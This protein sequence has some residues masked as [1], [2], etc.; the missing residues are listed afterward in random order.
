MDT[1]MDWE[2]LQAEAEAEARA[3]ATLEALEQAR[4][5]WLGR[6]GKLTAVLRQVGSL[7]KD[8]RKA[9]GE[10]SNRVKAAVEALFAEREARLEAEALERELAAGAGFDPTLPGTVE[11]AGS[12][13]PVTLVQY[14]IEDI[15][16]GLGF[17]VLDGP[18]CESDY[19][20]FEALNIPAYH[21]ARDAQDTFYCDNGRVLRTHTSACQGRALE[22]YPPPLRAIFPG[23]CFRAE[24]VDASHDM[25]FYQLE[26]LMI[27]RDIS[28]ANLI[29]VMKF[30]LS[31]VFQREVEVR[32]RPGYFPFVE[33]GFEL[34]LKCLLCGGAGCKT[35]K[36]SGWV[37][38]LPCGLVH[39]NVLALSGVDPNEWSGF[40]FGLGLTRLAMMKY[41]IND[42]R[43]LTGGDVRFLSQFP[44]G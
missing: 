37:E 18:E 35:C 9:F 14:E 10:A 39:P 1:A 26:G 6:H 8:R 24:S 40:A 2:A 15:F 5:A 42:I 44:A 28:V 30:L 17:M 33:P 4:T 41:G 36:Q 7:P 27:D 20:N 13:H 23:R 21:P 11:R 31:G 32:L 3:C 19:Y 16:A 22:R 25:M 38:M 12:L 43:L 29:A 34:D